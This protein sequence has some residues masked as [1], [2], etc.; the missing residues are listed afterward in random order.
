[1]SN[2]RIPL[3]LRVKPELRRALEQQARAEG[4]SPANL[5]ELLLEWSF[6]QLEAAGNSL[7]LKSWKAQPSGESTAERQAR[8]A[9]RVFEAETRSRGS[10]GG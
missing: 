3:S 7:E 4:R 1:M 9:R 8:T 2:K 6:A 5:A 10:R